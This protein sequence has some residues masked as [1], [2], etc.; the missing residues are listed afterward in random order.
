VAVSD[1][2]SPLSLDT[3]SS[4]SSAPQVVLVADLLPDMTTVVVVKMNGG[5]REEQ[6]QEPTRT[7]AHGPETLRECDRDG[8]A[9]PVE[10]KSNAK[11]KVRE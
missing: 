3:D 11:I 7:E 1:S 8:V 2:T 4:L 6:Q 5:K 10:W 9:I